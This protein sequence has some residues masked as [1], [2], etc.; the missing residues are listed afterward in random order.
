MP[1]APGNTAG[2]ANQACSLS[3][4]ALDA[5][6]WGVAGGCK[7]AH[8]SSPLL[9]ACRLSLAETLLAAALSGHRQSWFAP[10]LR[11]TIQL[12]SLSS[13]ILRYKLV[14]TIWT[15]VCNIAESQQSEGNLAAWYP[16][17]ARKDCEGD[18]Q[19]YKAQFSRST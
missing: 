10:F 3:R 13:L 16:N 12:V 6:I 9:R 7:Q 2:R 8:D 17:L 4:N 14:G 1:Y 18:A 19:A 5:P 11:C 15:P